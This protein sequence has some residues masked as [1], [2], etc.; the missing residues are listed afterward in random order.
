MKL[1]DSER[2]S[3]AQ[4]AVVSLLAVGLI[5]AIVFG[6]WAYMGMTDYKKN[7]DAKVATAVKQN[8]QKVRADSALAFAEESKNPL[9]TYTGPSEYGAVQV[10]YPKTWSAYVVLNGGGSPLQGYFQPDVVPSV[11]SQTSSFALRIEVVQTAYSQV[12]RSFETFQ[13]QGKASVTP[14]TLSKV[15]S[16][17]GSRLDGQISQN[18]KG[19]MI[20]LPMRDKT[21]KIWTESETMLKDFNEII[22]T[23]AS[24]SP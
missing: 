18:K 15:P 1:C 4:I 9:K 10:Q 13:K 19:A 17:V 23:N 22:L 12:L 3:A 8:T 21:L 7:V 5:G 2:G 24:F 16:V 14:F 20:I 6:V 11:T